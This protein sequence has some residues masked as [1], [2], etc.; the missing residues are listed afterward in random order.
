MP[1]TLIKKIHEQSGEKSSKL[2]KEYKQLEKEAEK[3][4]ATNKFAYATSVIEKMTHYKPKG[5]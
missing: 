4:K 5:K 3:N 2:E 1:N